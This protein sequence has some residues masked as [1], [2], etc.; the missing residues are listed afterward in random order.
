M[1][2]GG[3]T[4]YHPRWTEGRG[5]GRTGRKGRRGEARWELPGAL[6]GWFLS[7]F[8]SGAPPPITLSQFLLHIPLTSWPSPRSRPDSA[9][10]TSQDPSARVGEGCRGVRTWGLFSS[11]GLQSHWLST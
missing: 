2:G 10:G 6:G 9:R 8:S 4:L 11:L 7:G 3:E 5:K 1:W